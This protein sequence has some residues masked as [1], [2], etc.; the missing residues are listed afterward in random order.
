MF[1]FDVKCYHNIINQRL[2][3]LSLILDM[4]HIL[5]HVT[6]VTISGIDSYICVNIPFSSR[7]ICFS[8]FQL[9]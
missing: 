2:K 6:Y 3:L 5:Q 1:A 9:H 7:K 4:L 8:Y